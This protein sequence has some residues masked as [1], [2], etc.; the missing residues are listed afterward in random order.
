M[1]EFAEIHNKIRKIKFS[2]YYLKPLFCLNTKSLKKPRQGFLLNVEFKNIGSGYADLFAWPELGDLDATIQLNNLKDFKFSH[3]ILKSLYFAYLD[4]SYRE[5]GLNIFKNLELPNNHYTVTSIHEITD[6]FIEEIIDNGFNLLK[7]KLGRDV[8]SNQNLLIE[9]FKRIQRNNLKVRLDFNNSLCKET[10]IQF[11]KLIDKFIDSINFIEDPYPFFYK[12]IIEFK[13]KIPLL[14][15]ALDRMDS[16]SLIDLNP[17][18]DF[19]V[20]KPAIQNVLSIKMHSSIVITSYMDHPFGQLT[21]LYE[22]A[23]LRQIPSYKAMTCG[24]ITHHL[25]ELNEYSE[26]LSINQT[27]LIPSME[28]SGFGFDSLLKKE[29]WKILL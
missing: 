25:Y 5:K 2:E 18:I 4:A 9:T 17:C 13:N 14:N 1:R 27:R 6:L 23:I 28:G 26:A 8:F 19:I 15:F 24:L 3:Q 12:D 21:A 29:N 11:T 22:A 7:L 16:E 20:L 10:L